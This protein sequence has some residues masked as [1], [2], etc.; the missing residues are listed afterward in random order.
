[1]HFLPL[2]FAGLYFIWQVRNYYFWRQSSLVDKD[3][4]DLTAPPSVS[5]LIPARNEAHQ[6]PAL[7]NDLQQLDYPQERLRIIVIDDYSTDG[8][9]AVVREFPGVQLLQ[10]ADYLPSESS[11]VAHKKAAIS[12]AI[13]ESEA[14]IIVTTDA[15]C[16]WSP[17][18]LKA[19]LQGA[20]S[21]GFRSGPVLITSTQNLCD[22]FQALDFI[23]YMFLTAAY[24]QR[25]RPILANGANLVIERELF[26]QIGGYLG[27][28]HLP[29]GD[30]V[31]L[32]HKLQQQGYGQNIRFINQPEALVATRP[33]AGWR[34][35]WRQRL[36]WAG[37]SGAYQSSDLQLVQ[38]LSYLNSLAIVVGLM[39]SPFYPAFLLPSLLA[40]LLKFIIDGWILRAVSKHFGHIDLYFRWYIPSAFIYPFYLVAI[41]TAALLGFK[42][43]WKGR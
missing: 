13:Q 38:G 22:G 36:R 41:G 35:L 34:A 11:V 5:L 40:W 12:Y 27:V 1:M 15:D 32:L 4:Y 31:L 29:S 3:C 17:D 20:S 43:S 16:R 19:L 2:L 23:S 25:G 9:A 33:V 30:D 14:D 42:A 39:L 26:Q 6:L 18:T 7:L 10:L 21:I 24:A 37:K 8:T 28:D